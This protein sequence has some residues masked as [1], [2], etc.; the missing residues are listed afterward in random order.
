MVQGVWGG[1]G[2]GAGCG[3]TSSLLVLPLPEVVLPTQGWWCYP[4]VG[5][6]VKG[7]DCRV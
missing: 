6:R 7:V 3:G 4:H 1:D 5:C 2:G